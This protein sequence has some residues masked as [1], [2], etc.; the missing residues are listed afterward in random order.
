MEMIE[1]TSRIC[2]SV[3]V[4]EMDVDDATVIAHGEGSSYGLEL[5]ARRIWQLL[6]RPTTVSA[7]CNILLEEYK[8]DRETCEREV[9]A[10]LNDSL[11][12][13]LIQMAD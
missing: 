12:E 1:L 6:H 9:L 4:H 10:F 7:L 8:V 11:H 3:G 2:L 5:I 13:R